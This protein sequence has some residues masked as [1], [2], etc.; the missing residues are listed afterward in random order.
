MDLVW[1][2]SGLIFFSW[3]GGRKCRIV[4]FCLENIDLDLKG[5]GSGSTSL[6]RAHEQDWK[7]TVVSREKVKENSRREFIIGL[8]AD[9]THMVKKDLGFSI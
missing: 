1:S 9:D 2:G 4:F 6:I 7:V 8:H 3:G 5:I